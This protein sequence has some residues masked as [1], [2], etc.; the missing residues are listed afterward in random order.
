MLRKGQVQHY[1]LSKIFIVLIRYL[2][3]SVNWTHSVDFTSFSV[4]MPQILSVRDVFLAIWKHVFSPGHSG[5]TSMTTAAVHWCDL[6]SAIFSSSPCPINSTESMPSFM[7]GC[8]PQYPSLYI[9]IWNPVALMF[10]HCLDKSFTALLVIYKST[11]YL[12]IFYFKS[13]R[14][15]WCCSVTKL[16]LTLCKPIDQSTPGSLSFT[17][18]QSLLKL[19]STELMMPSK[20]LIFCYTL[21]LLPSILP[22][23]M[24][25]SREF[26]H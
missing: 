13:K 15:S 6:Y 10:M 5:L 12:K 8:S 26:A 14:I 20:H 16:Y 11:C 3:T 4:F 22:S 7:L 24:V 1:I 23:I 17:I 9:Y 21:L 18:A 25:F 2:C 19:M